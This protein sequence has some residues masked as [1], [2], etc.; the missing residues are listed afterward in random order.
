MQQRWFLIALV[1]IIVVSACLITKLWHSQHRREMLLNTERPWPLG[2]ARE[3]EISESTNGASCTLPS[4]REVPAYQYMVT[5]DFDRT[6]QYDHSTG[7]GWATGVTCRLDSYEH[8]T[9]K[10]YVLERR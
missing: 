2:E 6:L 1:A 7:T 3:C 4:N 8:A 10:Q 9:C 5:V